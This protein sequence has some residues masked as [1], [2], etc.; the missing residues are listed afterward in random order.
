MRK[1]LEMNPQDFEERK[2]NFPNGPIEYVNKANIEIEIMEERHVR[3]ILPVDPLHLN[4]V[5]TVYAGSMFV[6]AEALGGSLFTCTY[7]DEYIPV[8]KAVEVHYLKPATSDLVFDLSL[9]E[10]EAEEKIALA[11]ERGRG[12]YFLD[13][14]LYDKSGVHVF[15]AQ[16]N[17][18]AFSADKIKEFTA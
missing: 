7:G 15:D 5:G 2:K 8:L 17:Y 14:P 6:F 10:Q 13:I 4:H 12:D 9:T 11:A 18:Y 16:F 3:A 1:G